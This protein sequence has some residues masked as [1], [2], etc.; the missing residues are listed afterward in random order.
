MSRNKFIKSLKQ[1]KNFGVTTNAWLS[2]SAARNNVNSND[3]FQEGNEEANLR[4]S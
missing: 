4:K 3:K 2:N 1:P